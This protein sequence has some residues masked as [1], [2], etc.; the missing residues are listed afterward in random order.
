MISESVTSVL[1]DIDKANREGREPFAGWDLRE[2]VR[3]ASVLVKA[4]PSLVQAERLV[5]GLSN[6]DTGGHSGGA[7]KAE[8]EQRAESMDRAELEAYLLG[9]EEQRARS[10]GGR[11][12]E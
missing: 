10:S 4:L 7:I 3:T 9:R 1:R 5:A 12:P 8:A 2:K 6:S 11:P